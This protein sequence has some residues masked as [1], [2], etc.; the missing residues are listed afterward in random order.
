MKLETSQGI[1]QKQSIVVSAQALQSLAVLQYSQ[2]ELQDYLRD[3]AERN[4]FIELTEPAPLGGASSPG[5]LRSY[6]RSLPSGASKASDFDAVAALCD[7]KLS[8]Y[9]HLRSQVRMTFSDPAEQLIAQEIVEAVDADGYFRRNLEEMAET[10]GAEREQIEAVLKRVQGF[11]PAGIA[12]R[13][14]SECLLLQLSERGV[15]TPALHIL[16]QNL[17]L[18]GGFDYDRLVRLCGV[19]MDEVGAM[20]KLIRSCDPKPGRAFEIDTTL[21]AMPDVMVSQKE[22]GSFTLSL[23]P[24]CL[25]KVLVK[26]DYFAELRS[27]SRGKED[28]RFVTENMQNAS[29]LVRNLDQRARTILKVATEIVAQQSAFLISGVSQLRPLSLLDVAQA[30]G[31]HESTVC[32]AI[33]NKYMMTN[34][35][36]FELKFFFANG[37]SANNG[38]EDHAT[39]SVRHRIRQL[40][41]AETAANVLS[42]DA[43]VSNLRREGIDIARRTVAKYRDMMSIPSSSQRRKRLLISPLL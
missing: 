19:S 29:W 24:Q 26:N 9:D 38:G 30:V 20:L 17:S 42:D 41:D 15:M 27:S 13:N 22:D 36:M 5:L 16:L 7:V 43:I 21:P 40:V 34:R 10:L 11:E 8:L 4:P 31:V 25:P 2:E 35:G 33:A 32:R 39:A 3:E 37:L 12:A 18:L 23:T 28:R 6:E 14:L 1:F